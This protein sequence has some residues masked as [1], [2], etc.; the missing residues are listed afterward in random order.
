MLIKDFVFFKY[1]LFIHVFIFKLIFVNSI[2]FAIQEKNEIIL[3][4]ITV[5]G[6]KTKNKTNDILLPIIFIGNDTI[7]LEQP[8]SLDDVLQGYPSLEISG[9]PRSTS[10][11]PV[12][13]GIKRAGGGVAYMLGE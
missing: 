1:I 7:K 13:R 10:E 5:I 8:E 3:N 12:I 2:L 11:K 9:G 4:P 6:T